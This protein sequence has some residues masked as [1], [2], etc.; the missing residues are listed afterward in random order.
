M[1]SDSYIIPINQRKRIDAGQG[2]ALSGW[3]NIRANMTNGPRKRA[4]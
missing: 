2:F 3:R 1:N 4:F